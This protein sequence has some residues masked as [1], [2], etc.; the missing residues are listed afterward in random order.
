MHTLCGTVMRTSCSTI[1]NYADSEAE[2]GTGGNFRIS[3]AGP[4]QIRT[5]QVKTQTQK[6]H[7]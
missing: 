5:A 1:R 6:L 2:T 4:Q 3:H 7:S